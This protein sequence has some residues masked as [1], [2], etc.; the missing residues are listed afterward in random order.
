MEDFVAL[1]ARFKQIKDVQ[2]ERWTKQ[3]FSGAWN[4]MTAISGLETHLLM[5]LPYLQTVRQLAQETF[6][7][8]VGLGV[9]LPKDLPERTIEFVR[10]NPSLA[11]SML[12][13]ARKKRLME[14]DSLCG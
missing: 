12:Q 2:A 5:R 9:S 1:N 3:F 7:V 8:A 11:P 10:N 4:P 6:N 14:V 13:D